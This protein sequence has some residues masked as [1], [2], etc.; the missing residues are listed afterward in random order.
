MQLESGG[1]VVTA[2]CESPQNLDAERSVLGAMLLYPEAVSDVQFLRASDFFLRCNQLIYE[3]IVA[4]HA[5]ARR[6]DPILVGD[7]L[8]RRGVLREVGGRDVLLDLL[9][10]LAIDHDL[11]TPHREN[12]LHACLDLDCAAAG[13]EV[14]GA[15]DRFSLDSE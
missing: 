3:A 1:E 8:E 4:V 2:S 14:D 12:T 6:S 10:Y 9:D 7:E 15:P 11:K 5:K 13:R